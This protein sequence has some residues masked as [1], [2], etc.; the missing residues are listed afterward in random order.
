MASS[1]SESST[2]TKA[3]L[4]KEV[5]I[6]ST[7]SYPVSPTICLHNIPA[8]TRTLTTLYTTT[9]L[10]L[11]TSIQLALL[12]RER[13]IT[14]VLSA[15]RAERIREA[16]PTLSGL[17]FREAVSRIVDVEMIWP[18]WSAGQ[19][20]WDEE[21]EGVSDD[22]EM[23]F[24]TLSWWILHVGWKDIAARVKGSVEAV[25]EGYVLSSGRCIWVFY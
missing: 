3:Q 12:A 22:A 18:A 6:L 4:W 5:K 1:M 24:L 7:L 17:I 21:V 2:R 9:L 8:L 13:Y 16:S 20:D 10:S 19:E 15:E 23:R 14:S 25:F 11:L